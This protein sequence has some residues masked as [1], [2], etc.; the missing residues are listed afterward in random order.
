VIIAFYTSALLLCAA[1]IW[2]YAKGSMPSEHMRP[3]DYMVLALIRRRLESD[4]NDISFKPS[5]DQKRRSRTINGYVKVLGDKQLVTG[6]AILVAGVASW[7]KKS[8]L[9]LNIVT[10]LAYFGGFWHLLAL[11][12]LR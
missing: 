3:A 9:E 12:V 4:H 5:E 1:V 10:K 11:H 2:S 8:L 7:C 6:F